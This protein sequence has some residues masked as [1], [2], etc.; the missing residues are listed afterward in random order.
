MLK[1]NEIYSPKSICMNAVV[2]DVRDITPHLRRISL[3]HELLKQ[4]GP[5][6]AGVHFKIFI[7]LGKS[8]AT[9]LPDMS[10]GRPNWP[11]EKTKPY[12][13]TYTIRSIDRLA[14]TLSV[15]FVLHGDNGPASAWANNALIGETLGIAVKTSGKIHESSNWCLFAG[16]ETALPAISAMLEDLP[17]E[18]TGIALLEVEN[19]TNTFSIHT[20]SAVQ[21]CWLIR[22]GTPPERSELLLNAV[23]SITFPKLGSKSPFIWIAGEGSMVK[24]MR[25][26]LAEDLH[27]SRD[28][29]RA[30][31]YWNVGFREGE[32]K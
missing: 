24:A 15:E 14:G 18:T 23:K 13:R 11:D 7:P 6:A 9:V 4:I 25:K 5:L 3:K 22:N 29:F 21:I 17:P 20:N 26:Y 19:E 30:T 12:I 1:P 8:E 2:F 31:V 16:D 10:S 27:M 28:E 32:I